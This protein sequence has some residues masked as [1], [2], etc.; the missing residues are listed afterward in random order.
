ML[1]LCRRWAEQGRR[2]TLITLSSADSDFHD[3]DGRINRTALG[4]TGDSANLAAAMVGNLR[5]IAGL[6]RAIAAEKPDVVLS[7]LDSTNVLT[8]LSTRFLGLPVVV[9][10]RTYPGGHSIGR[11]RGAMRRI[12]YR[13]ASTVVAQTGVGAAWIRNH[14]GAGKIEVIPNFLTPEFLR[15]VVPRGRDPLV[16]AV[17]RLG[18]EKGFDLLLRAWAQVGG[19]RRGWRLRIVGQGP[20][21]ESLRALARELGIENE[22]ELP[23]QVADVRAEY[24]AASVFALPSRYEG[25]P[26]A[27]IE[28]LASGCHCVAFDCKTGPRE[29]FGRLSCGTLVSPE[30]VS[31]M[32]RAI[33]TS[34]STDENAAARGH[35]ASRAQAEFSFDA[36]LRQW[37]AV[38]GAAVVAGKN[39]PRAWTSQQ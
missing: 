4:L 7:F 29:I 28:A 20:E 6:R 14:T 8:L 15:E 5:R 34:M 2:V 18:L 37:E 17:G 22:L 26:N 3:L 30:D 24:L 10:E 23:G 36:G 12:S 27:L 32:A 35:L 11:F 25:F 21:Q 9:A 38:L 39:R 16:L 1:S 19:T 13:W 31:G 33:E